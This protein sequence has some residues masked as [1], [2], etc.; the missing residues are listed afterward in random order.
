MAIVSAPSTDASDLP[1]LPPLML[2]ILARCWD[3]L[4]AWLTAH[5]ERRLLARCRHHPLVHL[6]QVY[7]PQPV[8]QQP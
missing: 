5:V 2:L 1:P 6:A 4:L 8:I 7:D 3:T